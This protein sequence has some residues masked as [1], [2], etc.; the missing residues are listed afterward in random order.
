VIGVLTLVDRSED[1]AELFGSRGLPL[2]GLYTGS[3]LLDAAR[4]ADRS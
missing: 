3:E 2:I 4:A 1:A